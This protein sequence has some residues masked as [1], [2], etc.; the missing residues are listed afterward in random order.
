MPSTEPNSGLV[1]GYATG[2]SGWGAGM[3]ANLLTLGR[4][5]GQLSVKSR[6]TGAPPAT[7]AE[8]DRYLVGPAAT[9]AWA[10]RE[11]QVAVRAGGAWVF[12]TPR[13][14]WL[15]FVLDEGKLCAFTAGAWSAGITL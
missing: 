3:D 5:L 9:G 15:A 1:Y 11:T 7:P 14:G 6:A 13:P 2:E 12:Y 10:G 8:G 4:V